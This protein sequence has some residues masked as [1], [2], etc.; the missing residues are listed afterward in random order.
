VKGQTKTSPINL[1]NCGLQVILENKPMV[2]FEDV[3]DVL[4]ANP[5]DMPLA[6]M[7]VQPAMSVG[8]AEKHEASEVLSKTSRE[9]S[10]DGQEDIPSDDKELELEDGDLADN[11]YSLSIMSIYVLYLGELLDCD[12][13]WSQA[14]AQTL[15]VV[16][17]HA[18]ALVVCERHPQTR[19]VTGRPLRHSSSANMLG[20]C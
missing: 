15:L 17:K 14:R 1:V 2:T 4:M 5:E 3:M 8:E 6:D 12:L 20:H 16:H 19:T 13:V 7:I 9:G 10:L 11:E 18:Q